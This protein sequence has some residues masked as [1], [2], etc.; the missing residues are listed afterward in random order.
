MNARVCIITLTE[1]DQARD[2]VN[3]TKI[4]VIKA[5]FTTGNSQ[6]D[7]IFW[8]FFSQ[9]G[10]VITA[11]FCTVTAADQE[12]A[13]DFTGFYGFDNFVGQA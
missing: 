9:F 5:I 3:I 4:K 6:N 7:A 13:F 11:R 2:T 8:Q 1:I 12:K 10:V